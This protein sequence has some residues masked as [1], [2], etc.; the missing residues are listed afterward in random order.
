MRSVHNVLRTKV[1]AIQYCSYPFQN[2]RTWMAKGPYF[3]TL[4]ERRGRVVLVKRAFDMC[5]NVNFRQDQ[6]SSCLLNCTS[7]DPAKVPGKE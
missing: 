7:R 2:V 6:V 3:G 5:T 4:L 1:S